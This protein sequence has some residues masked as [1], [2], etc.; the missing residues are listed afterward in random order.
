ML[1]IVAAC[2]DL[3]GRR[4]WAKQ[5][6]GIDAIDTGNFWLPVVWTVRGPLY[7]EVITRRSDGR[8]HQPFHLSDRFKQPLYHFAYSLLTSL[9]A[10]P[11]VYLIQFTPQPPT[12]GFTDSK[13]LAFGSQSPHQT[14]ESIPN[15]KPLHPPPILFDRL[16]PFPDEPAIAS[17]GVQEPNLFACHWLCLTQQPIL[18]LKIKG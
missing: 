17:I 15:A 13:G 2:A 16:I 8:Y 3:E 9:S 10:P 5:I 11:A 1:E 4:I 7:A 18:D 12:I 6:H 14:Q